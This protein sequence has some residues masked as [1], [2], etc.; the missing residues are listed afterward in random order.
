MMEIEADTNLNCKLQIPSLQRQKVLQNLKA[1][2]KRTV[3]KENLDPNQN[4][5]LQPF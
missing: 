2:P 5:F 3:E 1:Q 4:N